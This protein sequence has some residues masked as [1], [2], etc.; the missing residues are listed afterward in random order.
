MSKDLNAELL[1]QKSNFLQENI[2]KLTGCLNP[3]LTES[4]AK[5]KVSFKVD[6]HHGGQYNAI[7]TSSN[8]DNFKKLNPDTA[9]VEISATTTHADLGVV[10]CGNENWCMLQIK[11]PLK[12]FLTSVPDYTYPDGSQHFSE[13][14]AGI[15]GV[16]H[17]GFD[18]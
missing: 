15:Y 13:V 17:E 12:C 11:P 2:K 14:A 7:F 10:K 9:K 8:I 1:E 5:D 3:K 6:S 4:G 18:S 16:T